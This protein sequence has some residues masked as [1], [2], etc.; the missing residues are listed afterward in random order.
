MKIPKIVVIDEVRDHGWKWTFKERGSLWAVTFWIAISSL[1]FIWP[2]LIDILP[3][4]YWA[5]GGFVIALSIG[6]ARVLK[7]EGSDPI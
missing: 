6:L 1:I 3:D 7:F 2:G 5:A 4:G